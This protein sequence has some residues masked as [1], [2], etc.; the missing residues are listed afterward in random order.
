VSHFAK[1][2]VQFFDQESLVAALVAVGVPASAITVNPTGAFLEDYLGQ[3]TN[4]KANVII[5]RQ[6]VGQGG[7][8]FNDIGFVCDQENASVSICD[9]ARDRKGY[10]AQWL[11][12]LTQEYTAA[13]TTKHYAGMGK[14][15]VRVNEDKVVRLYVRA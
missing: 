2:T 13:A 3:K 14:Q 9:Y 11:G 8:G 15:V 4:I 6:Y 1:I 10:N 5:S 12:R 7:Y